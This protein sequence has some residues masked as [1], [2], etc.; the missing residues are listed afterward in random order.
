MGRLR[1]YLFDGWGRRAAWAALAVFVVFQ[2]AMPSLFYAP[3]LALFDLY[4]YVAPR[5]E[6]AMPVVIVDIDDA[7]LKAIG[8]WPWPRQV[9]AQLVAK[10]V[11]AGPAAVG[12]DQILPEP[13]RQSPEEWLRSAGDM[14][15]ELSDAIRKLPSHDVALA[16]AIKAGNVMLGIGGLRLVEDKQDTGPLAPF[17]VIDARGGG[18]AP[19]PSLPQFNATLRSI[20][21]LDD[22]AG[23]RGVLSVDPDPDGVFRRL[24]LVSVLS[25]RLAPSM[26]LE[27]LRLAIDAPW[28]DLYVDGGAVL[29]VG[30]G[31][32]RVP[33]QD[34][35][36]VWIHFSPHD[37]RRFVSAADVLADRVDAAVFK[38][39]IVLI[40]VTGLGTT[41]LRMTPVG[42]MPGTEIN[43]QFL[44]NVVDGRLVRR[45]A[46]A[47]PA[48][49]ALT[50][51]LGLFLIVT[52]PLVRSH[53]QTLLALAPVAVLALLGFGVWR[54]SLLLLDVAT[55]ALGQALVF[56]SLVVGGFAEA[57]AHRRHLRHELERRKLAAA[58][59]EGEME[60]GR[61][62]QMG[63]LPDAAR[64]AGDRRFDL[65]ALMVPARQIGGDLY[66]FFKIDDE[67][68]FLAI[69]DVSGKGVPAALFMALAKS[70][71]QSIALR[72][73]TDLGAIVNRANGEIS[74]NNPEMLFITMF[75]AI[76]NVDTGELRFCNAG[77]DAP[78]LLRR[79]SPPESVTSVGGP[80]L[81]VM[82]DFA[83]ETEILQ[84]QPGDMLCLTTDGV[85]EA[86]TATGDLLGAERVKKILAETP[87]DA[88]AKT[89]VDDLY[90]A[91]GRFVA[92]A[93]ASDDIAIL[94]VRWNG[95]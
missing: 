57:D 44:E 2:A 45:P 19:P 89:V 51:A 16:Q 88:G 77:H 7:S 95:L 38:D 15:K 42:Y 81:C 47:A 14:P 71:C 87:P 13:D 8:Q 61:R 56:V 91:V 53:W 10:I 23:G 37:D 80:P 36:S 26:S 79:G 48:E 86:M 49:L 55:P 50:F 21:V 93:E 84:L 5:L 18:T 75:A 17:R 25:G 11:A 46:W 66:D 35:G 43:A 31:E 52:L 54:Q 72:G 24:P 30:V 85:G 32:L 6:H 1:R 76:L 74:R 22:A 12:I 73:E 59:T 33:T 41:D 3:R 83:Y 69:G 67:R 4:Q 92:G 65:G 34:D 28:I 62:I 64:I 82:E 70:L 78:F 9:D 40:G 39:K 27:M 29:G 68:L 63:M 90:A 58:K 20:P 60:A 94:T